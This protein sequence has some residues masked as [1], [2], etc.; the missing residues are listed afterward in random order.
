MWGFHLGSSPQ[1]GTIVAR[2]VS[3]GFAREVNRVPTGTARRFATPSLAQG[4]DGARHGWSTASAVH[5]APL[6][7]CLPS[8]RA[9]QGFSTRLFCGSGERE[10]K[11]QPWSRVFCSIDRFV[12]G[13][14]FGLGFDMACLQQQSTLSLYIA[15][16]K[17]LSRIFVFL[18]VAAS[19]PLCAFDGES[20]TVK[21]S[22]V[23]NGVILLTTQMSGKDAEFECFAS[24]KFCT[25]AKP[26]DYVMVKA[27]E[28]EGIYNDCTNVVLYGVSSG[29]KKKVGVYCWLNSGDCYI[30]TCTPVQVETSPSGLDAAAILLQNSLIQ[31]LTEENTTKFLS[32][33]GSTGVT[34]GVDGETQSQAQIAADF[35]G[36]KGAYCILF[37]SKCL[38]QQAAGRPHLC[39]VHDL[40]TR[41]SPWKAEHRVGQHNGKHQVYVALIPDTSTCSNGQGQIEFIFTHF[42]EGWKLVAV[43]YT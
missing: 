34:F 15:A 20:V 21:S 9:R 33:I 35:R 11:G 41:T 36:K 3:A 22:S 18:I 24:E 8:P 10:L 14:D 7:P 37:D 40:I 31:S 17:L 32:F 2:L 43:P 4:I 39:S 30:A 19:S 28:N 12:S 13:H 26:G 38:S 23:A 16:V 5:S 25:A 1:G 42:A 29:V 27:D 6:H